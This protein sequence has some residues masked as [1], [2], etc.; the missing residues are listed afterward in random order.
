MIW[1]NNFNEG[2]IWPTVD[3]SFEEKEKFVGRI[4]KGLRK[5]NKADKLIMKLGM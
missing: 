2:Y 5:I 3:S 4:L 1:K